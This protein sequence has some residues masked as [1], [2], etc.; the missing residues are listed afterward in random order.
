LMAQLPLSRV[1]PYVSPFSTTGSDLFGPF[2]VKIGRSRVKRWLCIYACHS[3]RA[4]HLEVLHHL[5]ISSY[6]N[7]FRRFSSRRGYVERLVLD[8]ATN[9]HGSDREMAEEIKRWNIS[10]LERRFQQRGVEFVYNCPKA[11]HWGGNFE[12]LIRTCRKHLRHVIGKESLSEEALATVAAEVEFVVNQR[13]LVPVSDDP[14]DLNAISPNDLLV[15]KSMCP[16][17]PGVFDPD[18]KH[19]RQ[20]WKRVQ[21]LTNAFWRR[22]IST[23]LPTLIKRTKWTQQRR[24]FRVGDLC[25]ISDPN[26][27][28]GHWPLARVI[29]V[30]ESADG[31]IR[32]VQLRTESGIYDRPIQKLCYLESFPE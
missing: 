9:H 16:L 4:V 1:Q 23:Y 30:N 27:P 22:W 7:A 28:R 10:D 32:S 6:I 17:P 19:F 8:N 12:R 26:A 11:S 2:F 14:S 15:Q 24:D 21:A 25:L 20:S 29:K 3:S 13:P 5:D 18:Q 31:R